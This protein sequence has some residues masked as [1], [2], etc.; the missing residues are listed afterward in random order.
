ML[1][2]DLDRRIAVGSNNLGG[3]F[4]YRLRHKVLDN[5]TRPMLKGRGPSLLVK[6]CSRA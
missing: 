6:G 2:D 4:W 1:Y 3:N 5:L